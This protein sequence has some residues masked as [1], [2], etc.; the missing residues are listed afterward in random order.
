MPG[1]SRGIFEN[2]ETHGSMRPRTA[3]WVKLHR[4]GY[5]RK[6]N[7]RTEEQGCARE[8]FSS[9]VWRQHLKRFE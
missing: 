4:A 8:V 2:R 5:L 1:V 9:R 7:A 3:G 6:R